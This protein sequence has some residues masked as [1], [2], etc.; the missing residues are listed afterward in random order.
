MEDNSS[1]QF[2]QVRQELCSLLLCLTLAQFDQE[3][4]RSGTR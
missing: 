3:A 4:I 1:A 2:D